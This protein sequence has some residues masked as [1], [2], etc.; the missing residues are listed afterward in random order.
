MCCNAARGTSAR[1]LRE[2]LFY[3]GDYT[4]ELTFGSTKMKQ[5]FQV[6]LAEGITPR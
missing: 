2:G 5:T 3:A 1:H 6:D 4:A